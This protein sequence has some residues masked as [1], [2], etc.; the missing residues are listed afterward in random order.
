MSFELSELVLGCGLERGP[1]RQLLEAIAHFADNETGLSRVS[2][3]RLATRAALSE[4]TVYRVLP[5]LIN[6]PD[7]E[8]LVLLVRPGGGRGN[9][10]VYKIDTHRLEPLVQA[11]RAAG[12]KVYA[13]VSRALQ[14]AGLAGEKA[15]P[16][17]MR[18]IFALLGAV[19]RAEEEFVTARTVAAL[20]EEFEAAVRRRRAISVIGRALPAGENGAGPVESLGLNPDSLTRNPDSLTI[21]H[22]KDT[23]PSGLSTPDAPADAGCGM[24]FAGQ[25]TGAGNFLFD[26]EGLIAHCTASRSER[27]QLVADLQGRLARVTRDGV[28]AIRCRSAGDADALQR[29]WHEALLC[30]ATDAGL[31]GVVF[32]GEVRA[33]P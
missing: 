17:N 3:S 29:R 25:A 27:L 10:A 30:W 23:S 32:D 21:A 22:N 33:P 14:D 2:L 9:A 26:V 31:S 24:I 11:I 28:L 13:G 20:A 18:A 19:L 16:E 12:R 15:T 5:Q 7:T 1:R 8:G 6:D 4:R